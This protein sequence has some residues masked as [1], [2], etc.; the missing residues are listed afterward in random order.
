M[1]IGSLVALVSPF[2][3][4]N[5]L[6][7]EALEKLVAWHIQSGTDAL[8]VG[9][10]TGEAPTL[11]HKEKLELV[12]ICRVAA[13]GK[14]KIIA[15]TGTYS[16]ARSLELTREAKEL[17][18]DGALVVAPYYSKPTQDGLFAHF[19]ALNALD[20]PIIVYH[21]P[22]R[23]GVT[24]QPNTFK[25]LQT[26]KNLVAIKEA[27]GSLEFFQEIQKK[28]SLPILSGDD[29]LTVEMMKKQAK[30]V[31]S[32]I[33]NLVPKEWQKMT[34]LCL[35]GDFLAAT[36]IENKYKNLCRALFLETNPQGVKY[37]LSLMGRCQPFLRLPL[38]EP[39][40]E[41]KAQIKKE[42]SALNL[43]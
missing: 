15:G 25:R 39:K 1:F 2:N 36:A 37:A 35:K 32:V 31:I 21:H 28:C 38:L 34:E 22:G 11:T 30:G 10:T 24:I 23:T 7:R 20:L 13:Q 33:A 8:V 14:L 9:G 40:E 19:Q 42:L 29:G 17:G 16:T 27:S 26:L 5:K 6:D 3:Q 12:E 4:K 18:A 41:I 43:I